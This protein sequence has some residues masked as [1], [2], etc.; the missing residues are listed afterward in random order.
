MRHRFSIVADRRI[1]AILVATDALFLARREQLIARAAKIDAAVISDTREFASA[2]GILSY[3]SSVSDGFQ[4]WG[5][6]V[7]YS[8]RRE[9]ERIACYTAY[10]V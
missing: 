6:Y 7:A 10:K 3:G 4:K 8:E 5:L 9:A 1:R 2:G